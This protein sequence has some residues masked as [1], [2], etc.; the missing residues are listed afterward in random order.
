MQKPCQ[1]FCSTFV[2]SYYFC[3]TIVLL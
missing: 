3:S 2:L 1:L